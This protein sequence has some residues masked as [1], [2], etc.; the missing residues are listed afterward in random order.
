[1][2]H[3]ASMKSFQVLQSSAFPL[4]S[5]HDL[6]IFLILSFATFSS[7]YLFFCTPED[8]SPMQFSLL[9][10]LLYVM[11]VLPKSIFFRLSEFLLVSAW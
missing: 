8:S 11:C 2:E 1:V 3:R 6:P 10:L 4:N 5:F 7:A 9:L